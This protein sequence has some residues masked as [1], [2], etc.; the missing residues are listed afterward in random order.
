[1]KFMAKVL[2]EMSNY[3]YTEVDNGSQTIS[4]PR[5]MND[6]YTLGIDLQYYIGDIYLQMAEISR[7]DIRSQY[8]K[9]AVS[10]L[11]IKEKI[12]KI[13]NARLNELLTQFYNNGGQ[14]IEAP[15][16]SDQAKELQPFFNR[17]LDTYFKRLESLLVLAA[18]GSITP[19]RLDRM[20]NFDTLEMYGSVS[21]L[22]K[23]DEIVQGFNNLI[24][25]RESVRK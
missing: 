12:E 2:E 19:E 1:M 3:I 24:S 5:Y 9:M 16:T 11:E 7:G 8:K 22:F 25:I 21:K 10:E 4:C 18:E 17:L 20:I 23:V 13:N 14:I 6:V 15:L